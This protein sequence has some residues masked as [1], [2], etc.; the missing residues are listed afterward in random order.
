MGWAGF[1]G[2]ALSSAGKSGLD[3]FEAEHKSQL[4]TERQTSIANWQRPKKK[5]PAGQ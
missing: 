3:Y 4:E 2:G 5:P 1:I